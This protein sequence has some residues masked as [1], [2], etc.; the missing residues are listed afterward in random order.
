[1]SKTILA[2]Q[3]LMVLGVVSFSV[4][5][6]Q[7]WRREAVEYEATKA[8][9][10]GIEKQ[11]L[12]SEG[13]KKRAE[14]IA[15]YE[16]EGMAMK[17]IIDGRASGDSRVI[18]ETGETTKLDK[19]NVG[20][21]SESYAIDTL[22]GLTTAASHFEQMAESANASE[23]SVYRTIASYLVRTAKIQDRQRDEAWGVGSSG[24]NCNS[25]QR[26]ASAIA[27]ELTEKISPRNRDLTIQ[28]EIEPVFQPRKRDR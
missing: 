10:G 13:E 21:R 15:D 18:E 20:T 24:P 7:S 25:A 17:G 11:R 2:V 26:T 9:R 4:W 8:T 16:A 5:L 23:A 22:N 6:G 1:M 19:L 3:V 27:H 14:I 12:T 28:P